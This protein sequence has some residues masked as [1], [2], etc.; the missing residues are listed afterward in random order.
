MATLPNP[1]EDAEATE[2]EITLL[3]ADVE[4]SDEE[5]MEIEELDDGSAVV[6]LPED[7]D[8]IQSEGFDENLAEILPESYLSSLGSEMDELVTQDRESRK[9]RDKQYAEGIRRT[10]LGN[11]A[12]GGADFE[13][14][15]RAV[16]PMLAKGCVDFASR[17]IKELM[18]ANGP[19]KTQIIGETTEQKIDK[20]ERKKT[21]VNWQ[22]T[23]QVEENRAELERLL[24]QLPLGGSQYKRWWYDAMLKRNRTETVYID[25]VV[26]PYNQSD[27]YTSSRVT[28]IQHINASEYDSRI[29]TGLYRDLKLIA[30]TQGLKD[31]TES[32]KATDK[33]EGAEEDYTAYNDQGLRDIYQI[34]VDLDIEDD[35]L[36]PGRLA[37]YILHLDCDSHRVLG[38]YRNWKESDDTYAKKHWMVEYNFIPWRGAYGV[39]LAQLIGSMAGAATGSLR[40]LLDAAH[41]DNFPGGLKLK[42]GRTAG[43][44][45][46]V[47]A[48]ELA[49]IDAP[50][51]VDDIRKLVMP[52]PFKG[53]S[54]VLMQLL[55]WLTQQAESVI[56]T[57]SEKIADGGANMPMGTAL[58]LIEHG[59]VNFSAIHARLHASLKRE[60][61]IVHRLNAEFL[62]DEEVV[63]E[64]G[65]LV[66]SREDFQGPMD[67]IPVSDPNI[68]SEAQRYAQAQ[69]VLQ[70]KTDPQF[71][72]YFKA[73]RLLQRLLKLLQLPNP[74][75]IATLPKDPK[76]LGALDENYE[77][78]QEDPTPL[79][80]FY[81]QDDAA[82]M[83]AHVHFMTSPMYGSN[84]MM[85]GQVLPPLL[86]HCKSHMA[87]FYK[88]H[89]KA[90]A[91]TFM[92]LAQSMG[93]NAT[94]EEAEAKAAAFADMVMAETL[95]P[96]ILPGLQK[97]QQTAMQLAPKPPTDPNIAIQVEAENNRKKM[98]IDYD[99]ERDSAD[100]QQQTEAAGIAAAVE[101]LQSSTEMLREGQIQQ[102]ETIRQEVA[103]QQKA[104]QTILEG[105]VQ[106]YGVPPQVAELIEQSIALQGGQ[107]TALQQLSDTFIQRQGQTETAIADIQRAIGELSTRLQGAPQ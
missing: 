63:E 57:A 45:I 3:E 23:T 31:R 33:V 74:D 61:E 11:D 64:L 66:V 73:D 99:R 10:G 91:E 43:Q 14:A 85:A 56:S 27:F 32:K 54:T 79:K 106:Q 29:S 82:H 86:A 41:I 62:T 25:D 81:D 12:P 16:H 48:T 100:R 101:K 15:S 94:R 104:M 9:E 107:N 69:A 53:P 47:N 67:I 24:S 98:Q 96:V 88:K 65:E 34:Y 35:P 22:M 1:R 95:G 2:D 39:G 70:L 71:A 68:F 28:H 50:P 13:G 80:V 105:A 21:Y 19:C 40:A 51:G 8:G 37:P 38:L 60:L 20:A 78:C 89:V 77:V 46:P 103:G 75:D 49:E 90:A 87:N 83:E 76:R 102:A 42:G 92:G 84:P 5:G 30:P 52:F 26:L 4:P 58:A 93:F 44:S 36:N 18:P 55:E 59:S 97:A 72:Q 17:A 6:K 7:D